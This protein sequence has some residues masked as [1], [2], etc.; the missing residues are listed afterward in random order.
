[1]QPLMFNTPVP[2]ACN[3]PPQ[4]KRYSPVRVLNRTTLPGIVSSTRQALNT[5]TVNVHVAVLPEASVAVQVTVV[6]PTGNT[7]PEAGV[8][9]VVTPGQLSDAVGANV[10]GLPLV[11][12]QVAGAATAM[13]AGQVIVGGCVSLTLT[14][15]EQLPPP[16]PEVHVTVV[17]PTGKNEPLEGE[18]VIAPQPPADVGAG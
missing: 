7:E 8:H 9:D 10:T 4:Q 6:V 18:Q 14:V 5:V 1:M 11:G 13:L 15:N 17:V 2:V 3:T 12:G 16:V